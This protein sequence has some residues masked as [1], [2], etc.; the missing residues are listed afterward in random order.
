M[1]SNNPLP[2]TCP[3]LDDRYTTVTIMGNSSGAVH[4]KEG[5]NLAPALAYVPIAEGSSSDAP[6][7]SPSPS[8]RRTFP[9]RAK[10]LLATGGVVLK[11]GSSWIIAMAPIRG[12]TSKSSAEGTY[13]PP[14]EMEI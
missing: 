11:G 7:I 8:E 2:H 12:F 10:R 9:P 14:F 3:S 6:V 13:P 4:R 5:P 1:T